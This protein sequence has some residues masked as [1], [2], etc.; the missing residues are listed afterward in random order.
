MVKMHEI[1]IDS[2]CSEGEIQGP[3]RNTRRD[4]FNLA[5]YGDFVRTICNILY[6]FVAIFLGFISAISYGFEKGLENTLNL[7]REH[8]SRHPKPI[9]DRT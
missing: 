5:F 1:G 8:V 4:E 9:K 7:Y 6:I 3:E 2:C